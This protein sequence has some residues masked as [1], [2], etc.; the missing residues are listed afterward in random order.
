MG[1]PITGDSWLDTALGGA[2]G[3]LGS[4]IGM[5]AILAL[6][7][8]YINKQ[9]NK[10]FGEDPYKDAVSDI[11][12]RRDLLTGQYNDAAAGV[13]TNTAIEA[14]R[15]KLKERAAGA[16][17][18][19]FTIN[20]PTQAVPGQQ[21][22]DALTTILQQLKGVT[23]PGYNPLTSPNRFGTASNPQS[24]GT[25]QR[26]IQQAGNNVTIPKAPTVTAPDRFSTAGKPINTGMMQRDIQQAGNVTIPRPPTMTAPDRY[27][28]KINPGTGLFEPTK[29]YDPSNNFTTDTRVLQNAT[30]P[31]MNPTRDIINPTIKAPTPAY[32]TTGGMVAAGAK[33]YNPST[34]IG[35]LT[36]AANAP[37]TTLKPLSVNAPQAFSNVPLPVSPTVN[38]FSGVGSRNL[39]GNALTES[40]G[41][42]AISPL[43][44][45]TPTRFDPYAAGGG[46]G[47]ADAD[48]MTLLKSLAMNKGANYQTGMNALNQNLAN[49]FGS[50]PMRQ[51]NTAGQLQPN[52]EILSLINLLKGI[53]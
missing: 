12:A 7:A 50:R 28:G 27:K 46:A 41:T 9:Q 15:E 11:K 35:S 45:P 34:S 2:K 20:R 29:I 1:N 8:D 10:N 36:S 49:R 17:L 23:R 30:N 53:A 38:N 26:D 21:S 16:P 39:V 52:A 25:M 13:T 43:T 4:D 37:Q 3:V 47:G 33:N 22:A 19:P 31:A 40:K 14:M 24:T 32:S 48:L 6:L 18:T 42:P 5:T 51:G 44:A